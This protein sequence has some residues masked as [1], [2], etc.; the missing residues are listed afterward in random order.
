MRKYIVGHCSPDPAGQ[1]NIYADD[2]HV[3]VHH[4]ILQSNKDETEMSLSG[5][6][7]ERMRVIAQLVNY[8]LLIW[9]CYG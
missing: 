8:S 5:N 9:H 2:T 6:K 3:H 7:K 1:I 4:A